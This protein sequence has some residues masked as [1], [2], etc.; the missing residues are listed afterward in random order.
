MTESPWFRRWFGEDYLRLYPH[1]DQQEAE[2]AVD[3][4]LARV[5]LQGDSSVLDLACGPGRHLQALASRG[6]QAFGLDLS[7]PLLRKAT[8][9]APGCPLVRGD[10]RNLPF[11]DDAFHLVTSFFTSFGYFETEGEDRDVLAEI[12]RIL[13]PGGH[14]L[15][16]YLNAEWVRRTLTPRDSREVGGREVVQARR[17]VEGG[18]AVEKEIVIQD[19]A[20]PGTRRFRERVRLY[21]AQELEALMADQGLEPLERL[22]DYQGGPTAPDA[23]RVILLA[24]AG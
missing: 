14:L 18:R 11:R 21:G 6:I 19:A 1:R 7:F 23:P 5:P 2:D 8:E 10:M 20:G 17:L 13:R 24:R 3:L 22:G 16:D 12:R 4:L 15:L 9:A